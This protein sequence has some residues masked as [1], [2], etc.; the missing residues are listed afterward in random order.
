MLP[1]RHTF[2]DDDV[3]GTKVK[4]VKGWDPLIAAAMRRE[5]SIL[6]V[7]DI[8]RIARYEPARAMATLIQLLVFRRGSALEIDDGVLARGRRMARPGRRSAD[9]HAPALP[10]HIQARRGA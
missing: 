2:E 10:R 3:S 4:R 9:H 6:V 7:R 5:F 1:D 8:D